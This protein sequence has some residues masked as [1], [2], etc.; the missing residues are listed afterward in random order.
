MLGSKP[1]KPAERGVKPNAWLRIRFNLQFQTVAAV[2]GVPEAIV[3]SGPLDEAKV[4]F[5][6]RDGTELTVWLKSNWPV[7]IGNRGQCI[8]LPVIFLPCWRNHYTDVIVGK[9]CEGGFR[10]AKLPVCLVMGQSPKNRLQ[11]K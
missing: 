6:F 3:R 4:L 8:F 11:R 9:S 7:P 1:A 10:M 5:H 2:V